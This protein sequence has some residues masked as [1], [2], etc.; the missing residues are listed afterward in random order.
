MRNP[1]SIELY[2][3][4]LEICDPW[5]VVNVEQDRQNKQI[6]VF[7]E[8]HDKGGGIPCP[9]CGR[10]CTI[11]DHRI[12]RLRH[13]DT[14]DYQI[15]LEVSVPRVECEEHKVEQLPLAFAEKNSRYTLLFEAFVLEWLK[16][17]PISAVSESFDLGLDAVDGITQRAVER[18]LSRRKTSSPRAI[19]IDESSSGKGQ[20]YITVILDKDQDCV[21]EVLED[22]KAETLENWFKTQEI[23][24]LSGLKSV[25]MDM[26][27]PY[28]KAVKAC[29]ADA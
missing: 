7:I 2:S 10:V 4:L 1:T 25:S 26:W 3:K 18:G 9:V 23:R 21:I 6:H 8:Y 19:G 11:H 27:D 14:R 15:I 24:Y 20:K 13:L 5:Q 22:R 16:S 29:R 28:I 17:S 12:R